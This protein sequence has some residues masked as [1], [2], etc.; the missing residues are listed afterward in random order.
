MTLFPIATG[1]LKWPRSNG[2]STVIRYV[3]YSPHSPYSN[4]WHLQPIQTFK[5]PKFKKMLN[6]AA[7]ATK[8][9]AIPTPRKTR[10]CVI[11][12]FKQKMFLLRDHLNVSLVNLISRF[13]TLTST[14][15]GPHCSWGNKPDLW[16]MASRQYWCLFC[17]YR[18]LDWGAHTGRIVLRSCLAWVHTDELL[19]QWS[20]PWTN[21]IQD[22]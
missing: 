12:S 10:G 4:C 6:I 8:G 22:R 14:H 15:L 5:H 13:F 9:I 3:T 1:P 11:L 7:Q 19:S 2:S 18:S 16:H 21:A 17:C 20:T